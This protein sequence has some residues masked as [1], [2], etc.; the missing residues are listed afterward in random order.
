MS[1]K[2]MRQKINRTAKTKPTTKG[3]DSKIDTTAT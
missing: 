1:S 2:Y 3:R